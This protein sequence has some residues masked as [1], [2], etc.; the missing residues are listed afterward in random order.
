MA[1]AGM[2]RNSRMCFSRSVG[3][4]RVLFGRGLG[5]CLLGAFGGAVLVYAVVEVIGEVVLSGVLVAVV[6]C[7]WASSVSPSGPRLSPIPGWNGVSGCIEGPAEEVGLVGAVIDEIAGIGL[8]RRGGGSAGAGPGS[9]ESSA[10]C[11]SAAEGPSEP[12]HASIPS[13]M[14]VEGIGMSRGTEGPAEGLVVVGAVIDEIAGVGLC[15]RGGGT[16]TDP[17]SAD[18]SAISDS[19][20]PAS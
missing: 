11:D 5:C 13:T 7:S 3:E 6:V 4:G 20:R 14:V 12:R 17:G 9:V 2:M 8:C 15:C 16:G 1:V 19:D 10:V 18:S